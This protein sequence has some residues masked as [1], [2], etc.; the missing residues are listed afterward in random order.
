MQ[1]ARLDI[2]EEDQGLISQEHNYADALYSLSMCN[3]ACSH[4]LHQAGF[5]YDDHFHYSWLPSDSSLDPSLFSE[6]LHS[7]HE[8]DTL[9]THPTVDSST[10]SPPPQ[11]PP[12]TCQPQ[13]WPATAPLEP[14]PEPAASIQPDKTSL[15]VYQGALSNTPQHSSH[16]PR[17][18]GRL[19]KAALS[20]LTD[21]HTGASPEEL[22]D[23]PSCALRRVF[24]EERCR[25]IESFWTWSPARGWIHQDEETGMEFVCPQELD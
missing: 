13:Q 14:L 7:S 3:G 16:C 23:H 8:R 11:S 4:A 25:S 17:A 5:I 20:I 12:Y 2:H 22:C 6:S 19:T 1:Q 18:S 21:G 24:D 10:S 15:L 9:S